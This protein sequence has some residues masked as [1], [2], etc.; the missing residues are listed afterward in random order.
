MKDA[1]KYITYLFLL[2]PLISFADPRIN[3]QNDTCHIPLSDIDPNEELNLPG[4]DGV[5][6]E[7]GGIGTGYAEKSGHLH[8][9]VLPLGLQP[10]DTTPVVINVN[11]QDLPNKT[12]KLKDAN[13]N[14]YLAS[15]WWSRVVLKRQKRTLPNGTEV[16]TNNVK[17]SA[18]LR[19]IDGAQPAPPAP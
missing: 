11:W 7:S 5:V 6:I 14:K 9:A 8:V 3:A 15:R 13:G 1:M 16:L 4:C 2:F 12:C 10:V 18:R 17:W 19:C